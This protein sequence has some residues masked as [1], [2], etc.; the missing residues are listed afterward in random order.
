MTQHHRSTPPEAASSL[1][2]AVALVVGVMLVTAAL[3]AFVRLKSAQVEAGYRI[4]D[5][6]SRL[7]VLDQQRAA[8]DVERSALSRP[9]RLAQVAR[10]TLGLVPADA[11]M[12]ATTSSLS[13]SPSSSLSSQPAPTSS[14]GGAP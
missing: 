8:L 1:G 14:A 6:R 3:V 7:V 11:S 13:T 10:T 12:A 2:M 5:L 4:H 9:S